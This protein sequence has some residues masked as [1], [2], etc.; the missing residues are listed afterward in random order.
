MVSPVYNNECRYVRKF[1]TFPQQLTEYSSTAI[2]VAVKICR[3]DSGDERRQWGCR[4]A[5]AQDLTVRGIIQQSYSNRCTKRCA[6]CAI[7]GGQSA[8]SETLQRLLLSIG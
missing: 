2:S 8:R 5:L 3:A 6:R 7:Q 1:V 4:K